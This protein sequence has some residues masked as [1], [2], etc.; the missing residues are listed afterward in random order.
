MSEQDETRCIVDGF[1]KIETSLEGFDLPDIYIW[2]KN[3]EKVSDGNVATN[4]NVLINEVLKSRAMLAKKPNDR[5]LIVRMEKLNIDLEK[6]HKKY[7]GFEVTNPLL[8]TV[9]H[10][11]LNKEELEKWLSVFEKFDLQK[12][13]FITVDDFFVILEETPT[14]LTKEI[15]VGMDAINEDGNIEFGDF[16]RACSTFC[17]FGKT[18]ILQ[19]YINYIF[20]FYWNYLSFLLNNSIH[21]YCSIG[22]F[23]LLIEKQKR[24]KLHMNSLLLY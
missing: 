24:V 10:L 7:T 17:M 2:K 8:N 23:I 4:V 21:F 14:I 16:I 20:I 18:E 5:N 12:E 9:E 11:A 19:W 1:E 22:Y 6:A 3:V 15:F 13:G